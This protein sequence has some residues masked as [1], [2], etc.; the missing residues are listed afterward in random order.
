MRCWLCERS[1]A[2]VC[3][4]CGQCAACSKGGCQ[5][6]CGLR[7]ERRLAELAVQERLAAERAELAVA[8]PH[9]S[10]AERERYL[11]RRAELS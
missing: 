2:V 1:A 10:P 6:G 8:C 9:W 11:A 3:S 5:R 7:A 4:E